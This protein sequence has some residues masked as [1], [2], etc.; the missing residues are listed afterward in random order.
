MRRNVSSVA[1]MTSNLATLA[2][3]VVSPLALLSGSMISARA[4]T[5]MQQV[6]VGIANTSADVSIFIADKEGYFRDAGIDVQLIPFNSA[7]QMIAPLGAGELEVGSGTVAAGLYNAVARG[8]NIKVVADKA[9]VTKGYEY[10][11][12]VVRKDLVDKGLYKSLKDLKGMTI[13]TAAEGAGSES[14]LNEALKKG[15][16]KFSDVNVV[17]M[18]F[19]EELSALSNKAIDAGITNEPTLSRIISQGI[20]VRAS[21]DVIYPGQQTAVLLYSGDFANK[22]KEVAQKFMNAYIKA[23][24][25]YYGALSQGRLA[26][27]NADEVVSILTEYTG[28]KNPAALKKM[29][30]FAVNP[31]GGVNRD[32]LR[33]DFNFFASR[34]LIDPSKVSVDR[35]V[36]NS[37]VEQSLRTLG[38]YA[39]GK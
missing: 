19:P 39:V 13:A 27:Q 4:A 35:V 5:Q 29:T 9:S 6:S 36:D 22:R 7:A 1:Q 15:G 34:G 30:P 17:H 25:F 20:A 26:G 12:L 16:L 38:P 14:S 31:D 28:L 10:S 11:T 2:F 32:A 3:V 21:P 8:I 18:G 37:F 24:R 33:N 23:L